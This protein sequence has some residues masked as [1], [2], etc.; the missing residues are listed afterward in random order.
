MRNGAG[1]STT[2][3]ALKAR[4]YRYYWLGLICYVLGHRAEYVTFAW[5]VWEVTHEPIY[6][7]ISASPRACRWWSSSSG[8][9]CWPTV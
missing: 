9:A 1:V 2:F 6:L 8:A 7:G 3:A 5:M 4:N